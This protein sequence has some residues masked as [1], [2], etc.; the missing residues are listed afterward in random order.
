MDLELRKQTTV[1]AHC[2]V[3]ACDMLWEDY[4]VI[5]K[6]HLPERNFNLPVG[7]NTYKNKHKHTSAGKV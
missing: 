3:T 1:T 5:K 6:G 7:R 4:K 2:N